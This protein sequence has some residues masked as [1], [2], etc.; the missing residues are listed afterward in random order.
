MAEEQNKILSDLEKYKAGYAQANE[1]CSQLME[2]NEEQ[3]NQLEAMKESIDQQIHEAI[4]KEREAFTEER[5]KT[6]K[7]FAT[8]L[9]EIQQFS[10]SER[11]R[12]TEEHQ[13]VLSQKEKEIEQLHGQLNRLFE[14]YSDSPN[15]KLEKPENLEDSTSSSMDVGRLNLC[16]CEY[17]R[18]FCSY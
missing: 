12:L 8:K 6:K 15:A 17:Y 14:H 18:Y 13:L 2:M 16:F 9:Q 11:E 7:E 3:G 1:I 10:K 4:T 5:E